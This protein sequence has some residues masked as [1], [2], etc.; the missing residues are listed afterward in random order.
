M[1]G[2]PLRSRKPPPLQLEQPT[3]AKWT[4]M[5]TQIFA[6]LMVDQVQKGNRRRCF[7]NKEA[8]ESMTEEFC[9][10]TGMRWDKEQLR[11]RYS[12]LK[13]QYVTVKSLLGQNDFSLDE[14][15]GAITATDNA[16]DVFIKEHPDAEI[17]RSS[18]FPIF[19]QLKL[20]FGGTKANENHDES[21]ENFGGDSS[22]VP[23]PDPV[24]AQQP[25]V[26]SMDSDGAVE[27]EEKPYKKKGRKGPEGLMADAILKMAYSSRLRTRVLQQYSDR[28]S[29]ADCVKAMDAITDVNEDIYYAALDLFNDKPIARELFLSLKPD[30]RL[31]WLKGKCIV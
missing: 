12:S 10:R 24:S 7:F 13:K 27:E 25:D 18:G 2:R 22:T 9:T 30:K 16:W 11:S 28:F 15:S 17:L 19:K 23:C 20:V 5:L 3:R 14:T 31:M 26:W 4:N 1:A 8:W 6:D 29:I 21:T